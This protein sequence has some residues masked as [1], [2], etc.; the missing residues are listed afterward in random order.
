MFLFIASV[1]I[2]LA[3]YELQYVLPIAGTSDLHYIDERLKCDIL[4]IVVHQCT[5]I[6]DGRLVPVITQ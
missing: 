6:L 3:A 2:E 4:G 5:G 1:L